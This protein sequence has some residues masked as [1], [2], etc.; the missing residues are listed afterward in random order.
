[1]INQNNLFCHIYRWK[2]ECNTITKKFEGKLADVRA[3]L[4]REKKRVSELTK[5]LKESTNKTAETQQMLAEYAHNIKRMEERV[6][7]AENRAASAN[8]HVSAFLFV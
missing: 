7:D 6:R 3:D 8:T 2:E 4:S 1:M 5:L